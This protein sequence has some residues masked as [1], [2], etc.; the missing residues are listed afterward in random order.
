MLPD[1]T[2]IAII[3]NLGICILEGHGMEIVEYFLAIRDTHCMS[4]T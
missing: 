2:F 1:D 4:I 3:L